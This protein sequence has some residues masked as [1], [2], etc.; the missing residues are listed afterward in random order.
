[1]GSSSGASMGSSMGAS[2]VIVAVVV[3]GASTASR[4][5][6]SVDL[7]LIVGVVVAGIGSCCLVA[8]VVVCRKRSRDDKE[9]A[10][11]SRM[12]PIMTNPTYA[13]TSEVW[14]GTAAT[15]LY[16]HPTIIG[17]HANRVVVSPAYEPGHPA[18]SIGGGKYDR[19]SAVVSDTAMYDSAT[20]GNAMYDSAT[21]GNTYDQ[22]LSA[23]EYLAPTA[24]GMAV[25][26]DTAMYDSA[27]PDNAMYDSATPDNTY[28][29]FLSATEDLAPTATGTDHAL[30][31]HR[32]TAS[33]GDAY[34]LPLPLNANYDLPADLSNPS[35]GD[36]NTY[37]QPLAANSYLVPE[38]VGTDYAVPADL[39]TASPGNVYDRAQGLNTDEAVG[40]EYALAAN[41]LSA[42]CPKL[43][44][45]AVGN[46]YVAYDVAAKSDAFC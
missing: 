42:D 24:T 20:P 16:D 38:V 13:R 37:D 39:S 30:P 45:S 14:P 4:Q 41:R 29:Q 40:P 9:G 44:G 32:S 1:M 25:V 43:P 35:P 28:A 7:A 17:R 36:T 8:L 3:G 5:G 19:A 33:P 34:D 10:R 22:F 11:E 27:T 15:P 31:A 12:Q 23:P 6:D 2:P 26:S 21:P 18:S 46:E